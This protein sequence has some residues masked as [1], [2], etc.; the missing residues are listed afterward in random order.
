MHFSD[1]LNYM[2]RDR[3]LFSQQSI[4]LYT[5]VQFTLA[6][7][8]DFYHFEYCKIF[9]IYLPRI[10]QENYNPAKG[11]NLIEYVLNLKSFTDFKWHI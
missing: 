5:N 10:L 9:L 11:N 8:Y 3:D 4:D 1:A 7:K 6:D 2:C